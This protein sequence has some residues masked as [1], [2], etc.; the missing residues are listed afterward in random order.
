M[1]NIRKRLLNLENSINGIKNR[2][3]YKSNQIKEISK[4]HENHQT[5]FEKLNYYLTIYENI[6]KLNTLHLEQ[7]KAILKQIENCFDK[8][9]ENIINTKNELD[10]LSIKVDQLFSKSKEILNNEIGHTEVDKI[11]FIKNYIKELDQLFPPEILI[12][13]NKD[14]ND[15][16]ISTD[17]YNTIGQRYFSKEVYNIIYIYIL[18]LIILL[19]KYIYIYIYIIYYIYIYIY[20]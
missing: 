2:L 13:W 17:L 11:K 6:F 4:A 8:Q 20:I 19:I 10:N 14:N 18:V 1:K 12:T 5:S 9:I 3:N 16:E 7:Q 15:I